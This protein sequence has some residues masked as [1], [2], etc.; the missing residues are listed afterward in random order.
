MLKS[1]GIV[2][3]AIMAMA[4]LAAGCATAIPTDTAFGPQSPTA[5][6][7]MA[8]PPADSAEYTDFRRVDLATGQFHGELITIVNAGFGGHQINGDTKSGVWLSVQEVPAGDYT[9]TGWSIVVGNGTSTDCWNTGSPV[10]NLPAGS[11]TI[12]NPDRKQL[13][14][15]LHPALYTLVLSEFEAARKSYP[16]IVGRPSVAPP[17]AIIKWKKAGFNAFTEGASKGCG[18]AKTFI[19]RD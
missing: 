19:E 4:S 16:N 5:L 10:F 14:S 1:A 13:L 6:L 8:S 18:G 15:S 7:V 11:I 3:A 9:V 2:A 12:V 17:H